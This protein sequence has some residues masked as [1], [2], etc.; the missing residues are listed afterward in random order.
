MSPGSGFHG[1][2]AGRT[3]DIAD[4]LPDVNVFR[5]GRNSAVDKDAIGVDS[6]LNSHQGIRSLSQGSGDDR[7]GDGIGQPIGVSRGSIFGTLI[8][9]LGK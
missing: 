1:P 4:D 3:V 6:H 7:L 2:V 5:S 8:H 9:G